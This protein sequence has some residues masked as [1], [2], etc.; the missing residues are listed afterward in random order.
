M[1][2]GRQFQKVDENLPEVIYN[3]N[4]TAFYLRQAEDYSLEAS[5]SDH[6]EEL[7]WRSRA[8]SAVLYLVRTKN[9]KHDIEQARCPST[10]EWAKKM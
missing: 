3:R 1:S 7:L 5:L 6:S 4:R 10:G 8:F 2:S 9:I